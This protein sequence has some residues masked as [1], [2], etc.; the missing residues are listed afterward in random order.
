MHGLAKWHGEVGKL[1]LPAE[2]ISHGGRT[3]GAQG[4]WRRWRTCASN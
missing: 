2:L 4:R 3:Q 1:S